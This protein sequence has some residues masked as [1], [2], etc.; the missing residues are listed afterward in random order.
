MRLLEWGGASGE[1]ALLSAPQILCFKSLLKGPL[2]M[3][4]DTGRKSHFIIRENFSKQRKHL[5]LMMI[6]CLTT[7]DLHREQ[8]ELSANAGS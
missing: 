8:N 6:K 7:E 3:K 4:G 2:S 5:S 1:G